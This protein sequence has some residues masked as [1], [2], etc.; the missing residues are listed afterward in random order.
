MS[1][2]LTN[3][4][5]IDNVQMLINTTYLFC[6]D[7]IG[8]SQLSHIQ[9]NNVTSDLHHDFTHQHLWRQDKHDVIHTVTYSGTLIDLIESVYNII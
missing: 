7:S 5:E 6:F 1:I 4:T 2:V 9:I 3:L 8:L